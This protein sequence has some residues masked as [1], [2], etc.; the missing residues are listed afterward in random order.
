MAVSKSCCG[1]V[2]ASSIAAGERGAASF[3]VD[4][5]SIGKNR[6]S[7][8]GSTHR[9]IARIISP[10]LAPHGEAAPERVSS[11]ARMSLEEMISA[12]SIAI[13]A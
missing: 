8:Y 2:C 7:E 12:D 5:E 13:V 10:R 4:K 1:A 3:S 6:L 9:R 11:M